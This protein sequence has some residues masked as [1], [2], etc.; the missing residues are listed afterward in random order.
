M[1]R[2]SAPPERIGACPVEEGGFRFRVWA[3][4]A[5]RLAVEYPDRSGPPLPLVRGD[6]GYFEATDPEAK[7]GERYWV[8]LGRRRLPDPASRSQPDGLWGP[9]A[10]VDP[11]RLGIDRAADRD[12]DLSRAVLYEMHVGTFS[13]AGTFAGAV[14]HLD[15]L[16]ALGVT[17]VELLPIEE[18]R[19]ERGWGYGPV[20]QF[21]VRRSYGGPVGFAK[22]VNAA[23][24]RGL[25]VLLDVV[26]NHWST[27]A[28][29]LERFGPYFHATASTPWGPTPNMDGPGADEVRSYLFESA[30]L[31]LEDY[32]VDGFRLDAVHEVYDRS[33]VPFW[34][35]FSARC[36]ALGERLGR[37]PVL[38][39]ESDLN[40]TKIFRPPSAGGWGLD[41][42]WSD[43]FHH[44]L[45]ATLTGERSGYYADFGSLEL[46]ARAFER[47]FR[48]EGEYSVFR[49]RTHGSPAGNVEPSRFVAF[50]QNHDQVGNRGDGAR[51]TTLLSPGLARIG[52]GLLLFAPYVPMLFMGEEYGEVR[53]FFFFA[54]P[55]TALAHRLVRGRLRQ[56]RSNGFEVPP[57]DPVDPA[58]QDRCRLDWARAVSP[59]GIAHR[60]L[61]AALLALRREL[62]ALQP[63]GAT[64]ATAT[65]DRRTLRV[66][67][68]LG[69]STAVL[70]ANLGSSAARFD[71]EPSV[72]WSV[73]LRSYESTSPRNIDTTELP[74]ANPFE[75]PR[76]SFAI[77]AGP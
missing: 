46:L 73:R 58:T 3:P 61:V 49:K 12:V 76:E 22:F 47:P 4:R 16:A 36:R 45:H 50:D 63:G 75:V 71:L 18:E 42:Q 14:E 44:A 8:R 34:A 19:G 70:F 27:P 74:A 13:A 62:P 17:A 35:E 55:P 9:S 23:H 31:W 10:L 11:S 72:P 53:P 20:H 54:D 41:A 59:E 38:I 39:A 7:V 65:E 48:F 67:R 21:A 56:L 33:S 43:D 29:F 68:N 64:S 52:L 66:Q 30:R 2:Y 24:A 1:D 40:D 25:A 32:G 6:R 15:A 5:R 37:R 28:R 26:Y 60:A 77:L 57:P 69:R 51:L